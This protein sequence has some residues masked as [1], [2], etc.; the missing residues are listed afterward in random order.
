M[1]YAQELRISDA[2]LRRRA[3]V[4]SF[5]SK[6]WFDGGSF[7]EH[8]A[9]RAVIREAMG[10]LPH[11]H[12]HEPARQSWCEAKWVQP[13]VLDSVSV[14]TKDTIDHVWALDLPPKGHRHVGAIIRLW[15]QPTWPSYGPL[16]AISSTR[17]VCAYCS[18][19]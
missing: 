1:V 3:S 11:G 4:T 19:Y 12:G 9:A 5:A 18:F 10:Q 14:A 2:S 17:P 16:L 6:Q 7:N 15:Y 8:F 13:A